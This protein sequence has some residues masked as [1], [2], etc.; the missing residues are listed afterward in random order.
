LPVEAAGLI[1][2]D[3]EFHI[4]LIDPFIA[5]H[6][7]LLRIV[8]HG[9]VPPVE[10][11]IG[12]SLIDRIAVTT[13]GIFLNET[14]GDIIDCAV[15]MQRIEHEKES[16]FVIVMFFDSGTEIRLDGKNFLRPPSSP[17]EEE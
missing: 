6:P 4:F 11:G 7:I 15:S 16:G 3:I 10:Q 13:P 14:P 12:L 9:V 5:I 2:G 17:R 1:A 8:I